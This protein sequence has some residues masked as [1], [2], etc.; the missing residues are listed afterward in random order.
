MFK[1]STNTIINSINFPS[2][3]NVPT[4]ANGGDTI[5][6][7]M[8]FWVEVA[9]D[10][11]NATTAAEYPILRIAHH[12]RFAKKNVVAIYKRPWEN[13]QLFKVTFDVQK[14]IDAFKA[15]G[16]K[17]GVGRI[18]IYIRLSGSQ[19]SYYSNDFVFKGKPF[20]IEFPITADDDATTLTSKIVRLARKYQNFVYEYPLIN[21][22]PA[23]DAKGEKADTGAF[24][25]LEGTD[26]YQVIKRAE[27][28]YYN[29]KADSFDCCTWFGSFEDQTP[30][31]VVKQGHEGF[32]TYRQI[33]KDLRLP[34]AANT[35]WT[36]IAKDDMPVFGGHYNEYVIK[37]CVNRGIMGSDAVGEVT[38]SLTNHVFYV[39]D[40]NCSDV[41][42][43][44][45]QA[46]QDAFGTEIITVVDKDYD[47]VVD[48]KENIEDATDDTKKVA[49]V[50]TTEHATNT[51]N[52]T[53]S[54][55]AKGIKDGNRQ[56]AATANAG[57]TPNP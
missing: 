31:V 24:L 57:T 53:K 30:G 7:N 12:F 47:D 13:P 43:A 54:F 33:I 4:Q 14:V 44:W 52:T 11:A 15:S 18:A 22:Y 19:N 20:Y 32:G 26:E 46:L 40:D 28:Q 27:L 34:T 50:E 29:E 45:E 38:K 51:V 3:G 56:P 2:F 41:T 42:K 25:T 16:D 55:D 39:L 6:D 23:A 21:I 8:R 37:M 49:K 17:K 36:A 5:K 48:T 9:P 35:R 1:F 10:G